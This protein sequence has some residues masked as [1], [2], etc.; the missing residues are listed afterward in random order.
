MDQSLPDVRFVPEA[1][2]GPHPPHPA[3]LSGLLFYSRQDD[4][5]FHAL[6]RAWK[7]RQRTAMRP[8][9]RLADGKTHSHTAGLRSEEGIKHFFSYLRVDAGTGIDNPRQDSAVRTHLGS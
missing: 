8:D 4:L 9:D 3:I 5:K 2:I 6:R 7:C 1:D